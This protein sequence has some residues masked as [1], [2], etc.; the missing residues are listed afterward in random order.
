MK[1][2]SFGPI[3]KKGFSDPASQGGALRPLKNLQNLLGCPKNDL[4]GGVRP[5]MPPGVS[6]TQRNR[7]KN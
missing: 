7:I 2:P 5:G 6:K 4:L 3:K 1:G